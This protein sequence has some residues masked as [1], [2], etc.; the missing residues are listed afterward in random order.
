MGVSVPYSPRA[1]LTH[2]PDSLAARNCCVTPYD[3]NMTAEVS[4]KE[5]EGKALPVDEIARKLESPEHCPC[6]HRCFSA[7]VVLWNCPGGFH[8]LETPSA[9]VQG[10]PGH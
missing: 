9:L 5:N 2:F 10:R 7:L 3:Q 6:R 4:L 8:N 1:F